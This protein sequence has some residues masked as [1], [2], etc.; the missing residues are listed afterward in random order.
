MVNMAAIAQVG[1]GV[2]GYANAHFHSPLDEATLVQL[3]P[4]PFVGAAR[5]GVYM[6]L[7]L[8]GPSQPFVKG[9]IP[10]V[11][12]P[13]LTLSNPFVLVNDYSGPPIP[14]VPYVDIAN[15][16]A[17]SIQAPWVN[18]YLG[19][20]N[21]TNKTV[22]D[23]AYDNTSVGIIIFRGLA[24]PFGAGF[25]AS[26]TVK[27]MIGMEVVP[28]IDSPER[29][30]VRV[31]AECDSRALAAYYA[32]A[33]EMPDAFPASYNFLG[34]LLPM[35]GGLAT[36]IWPVIRTAL[37]QLGS[38]VMSAVDSAVGGAGSAGSYP[39]ARRVKRQPA[40][41]PKQKSRPKTRGL[42]KKKR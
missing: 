13:E 38:A 23:T 1:G 42:K 5:D 2:L 21:G 35:L 20:Y 32:L 16:T 37:P 9:F 6:P 39:V 8:Q 31:A 29:T 10:T 28:R 30:F 33:Y 36:K 19:G 27:T 26:V 12:N 7:R 34:T 3:S 14:Q 22:T 25:G 17:N 24:G 40:P 15:T 41:P 18:L 4:E 11:M